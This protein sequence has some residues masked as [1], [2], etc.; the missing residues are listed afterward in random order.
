MKIKIFALLLISVFLLSACSA[1]TTQ[2]SGSAPLTGSTVLSDE[3]LASNDCNVAVSALEKEL[4]GLKVQ[5]KETESE[6]LK[7]VRALDKNPNPE[8]EAKINALGDQLPELRKMIENLDIALK[9]KKA[10]CN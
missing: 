10:S 5:L 9:E 8:D 6:F 2:N 3:E 1:K 4:E 7:G